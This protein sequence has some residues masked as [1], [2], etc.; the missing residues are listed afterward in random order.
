[1]SKRFYFMVCSVSNR[2]IALLAV[3]LLLF[4]STTSAQRGAV[5]GQ[6]H[7]YGGD[8]GHSKYAPLAQITLDNVAD[9]EIVWRWKSIDAP[10]QADNSRYNEIAFEPTPLMVDG[11]LYTSTSLSQVAAID[12]A[13]GETLWTYDP[14]SYLAGRPA[15]FGFLHRG[16]AYWT[17][18]E[19]SRVFIP[20][21]DRR[22]IA[23]N[24]KNGELYEDFGEN[25]AVDLAQGLG[26]KA[27]NVGQYS[28]AST[29]T[30][31]GNTVV[32]GSSIMDFNN[33]KEAT[34]GHVRGYD[35]RTGEMKWIFHTIPQ[36]GEFGVETWEDESWKYTGHTN[37][38]SLISADPELGYVY[39]PVAS[40]TN[41][42]Y[43][44]HHLG[45]NLFA[46][47]LVCVDADTGE[48]VWHF[49]TLHHD[50]FDYDLPA[51]PT[52]MDINVDGKPIKAV[53][54]LTKQGLIFVLDRVTGEPV[55][56]IEETPVGQSTV[57]GERSSKTQPIPTR[58]AP[59]EPGGISIDK[60]IDFTPELRQQ[61]IDVINEMDWGPLYTPTTERGM[62]MTPG[63]H[64][65]ASFSGA[66]FD[67]DT[68][69]LYV[70][71][72]TYPSAMKLNKKNERTNMNYTFGPV[73]PHQY[74]VFL[75]NGLP[76]LKPPYSRFTAIDMNTGDHL[77]VAA[78]GDKYRD[79]AAL[80]DLDLPRLGTGGRWF[81]LLT[82][83]FLL[84]TRGPYLEF[85]NKTSGEL[86]AQ[87]KVPGHTMPHQSL[88][89]GAPMTYMHNGKQ[90][91]V[92]TVGGTFG[93][94]EFIAWALPE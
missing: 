78:L 42:W 10:I 23:L 89:N 63:V 16:L 34:P 64:G 40:A 46:N 32:L 80:K 51:A 18:G 4:S 55:W 75:P 90:Y 53:V 6:W 73:P 49:Q 29:P 25:G 27:Q 8:L 3:A 92:M 57:P 41:D 82:K 83:T 43:G 2:A 59:F 15:N 72:Q 93:P 7:S 66:S 20:T 88:S 87:K 71:S 44:G 56:P 61:A 36:E 19:D 60:L 37:V 21:G 5:N 38:W 86:I 9:L 12:P 52:L 50:S 77:W 76:I 13:T 14:K 48:R 28:F 91:I 84:G 74:F 22:L 1:M 69:I 65:G 31:I 68:N 17:D 33:T 58:P 79:H 47:S 54:Q 62:F 85:F 94:A 24:T 26:R 67:P 45:D 39:L 81:P 35:V 11:I 70:P 30:V